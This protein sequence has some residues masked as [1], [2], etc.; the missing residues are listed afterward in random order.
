MILLVAA[1]QDEIGDLPGEPLG[2]GYVVAAARM[3]ALLATQKPSAVVMLGT[4]GGYP[5]GPVIGDVIAA[6]RTGLSLG[7]AVMGLGYVPRP[8]VPIASDRRL[9][10]RLEVPAV[11]VL[12]VGAIT[13]DSVLASRLSDG[14]QAE[15][16]E[17]YGTAL[18]CEQASIPFVGIFGISHRAGPEAHSQWLAHRGEAREKVRAVVTA[19]LDSGQEEDG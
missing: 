15:Q 9:V 1:V 11:D 2:V 18:A 7:V 6:R 4:A 16:L 8:P 19:L 5:G 13:T 3:A 14:W 12:S 10:D 17:A